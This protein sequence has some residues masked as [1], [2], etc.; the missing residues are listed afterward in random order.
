MQNRS[1]SNKTINNPIKRKKKQKEIKHLKKHL[2]VTE[3]LYKRAEILKN[4][5]QQIIIS[6]L[7]LRL[8]VR[9]RVRVSVLWVRAVSACFRNT[10]DLSSQ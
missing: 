5:K 8:S 4:T 3:K 1:K 7:G 10:A 6:M 2:H 9:V